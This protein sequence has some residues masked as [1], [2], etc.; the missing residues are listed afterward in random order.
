MI[1]MLEL[2]GPVHIWG[3]GPYG[4][5]AENDDRGRKLEERP[6]KDSREPPRMSEWRPTNN[7]CG[8]EG[9]PNVG[10]RAGDGEKGRTS[11]Y[12]LRSPTTRCHYGEGRY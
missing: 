9:W 6:P 5:V 8:Q 11:A 4:R 3:G 1:G 12:T 7:R 2:W 10:K